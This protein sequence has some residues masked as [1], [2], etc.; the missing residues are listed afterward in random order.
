MRAERRLGRYVV[1]E[2]VGS[3]GLAEVYVAHAEGAEGFK[4][5]LVIKQVRRELVA[6]PEAFG[7]LLAEAQ[8]VQR[9]SHGNIVQVFDFGVDA[10][11]PFVVMEHVDGV[12]LAALLA[13][14]RARG[15]VEPAAALHVAESLCA[16]L[17]YAHTAVDDEDRPLGLVHRDVTPANVLVSREGL[18]KLTDFGIALLA[19]GSG[20][21]ADAG[22]PGYAAPEQLAGAAVD[23]RA[24]VYA[25]GKILEEL[26]AALSP[27]HAALGHELRG[28][29]ARATA[30]LAVR[31]AEAREVLEALEALR[32]AQKIVRSP[33]PL[34]AAV[35]EI[36][37]GRRQVARGLAAALAPE[38]AATRALA[39]APSRSRR[40]WIAGAAVVL[41]SAAW[42][43][44]TAWEREA[45]RSGRDPGMTMRPAGTGRDAE[46]APRVSD[47]GTKTS[48]G[49]PGETG[50]SEGTAGAGTA[51]GSGESEGR[52]SEGAVNGGSGA[53]G[54]AGDPPARTRPAGARADAA[55]TPK[56]V[57][58]RGRLRVNLIPWAQ[59]RLD[60][61]DLG[62]TPVDRAVAPGRHA[63]ELTNPETGQRR[64]RTIEVAA[65]GEAAIVEW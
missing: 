14:A 60:G 38:A 44:S 36:Q 12:P 25:L 6:H 61:E 10:G 43:A 32:V 13:D 58:A 51:S 15:G 49:T 52:T 2:R 30:P 41:A 53:L 59:V 8:L 46:R 20:A 40:G 57:A 4:K 27:G 47:A 29:A 9:L 3:G 56:E 17:D 5:R 63:L 33:A 23:R 37:R 1:G 18:V 16:A 26:A 42:L 19:S 39:R 48:A 7:L 64:T 34:A 28:L 45:G 31:I 50:A 35:R 22:T 62:R 65:G 24:D 11:A 54:G 21:A 55:R